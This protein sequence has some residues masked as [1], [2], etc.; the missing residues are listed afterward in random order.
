MTTSDVLKASYVAHARTGKRP[1]YGKLNPEDFDDIEKEWA[2][3]W[4][5]MRWDETA[6]A[7][8]NGT[9]RIGGVLYSRGEGI[10]RGLV[11]FDD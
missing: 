10:T 2:P 9:I 8:I 1:R 11:R 7:V 6:D 4:R 3:D 5:F